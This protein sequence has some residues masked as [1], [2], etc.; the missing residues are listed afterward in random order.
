ME[1]KVWLKNIGVGVVKNGCAQSGL[2]TLK[3]V[4]SQKGINEINWFLVC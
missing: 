1:I 4:Q 2:R 3:F